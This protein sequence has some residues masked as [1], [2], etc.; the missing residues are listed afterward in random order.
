MKITNA[1]KTLLFEQEK[2]FQKESFSGRLLLTAFLTLLYAC[3]AAAFTSVSSAVIIL[4]AWIVIAAVFYLSVRGIGHA[5]CTYLPILAATGYA[6]VPLLI[7]T[8]ITGIISTTVGGFSTILTALMSTAVLLWCIPIWVYAVGA[9]T[10]L[11]SKAV[12][13]ILIV[14]ILLILAVE[15]W[16]TFATGSS[17]VSG[18]SGTN[19]GIGGVSAVTEPGSSTGPGGGMSV[20]MSISGGGPGMGGGGGPR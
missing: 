1:T 15:L 7:G 12:L 20:S 18:I 10:D 2:F 8:L 9:V 19:G 11:S 13:H 4:I 5:A 14:P 3:V 16:S 17:L 6:S